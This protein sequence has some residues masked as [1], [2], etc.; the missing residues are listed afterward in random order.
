MTMRSASAAADSEAALERS[1]GRILTIGTWI[2]IALLAIGFVLLL[3]HGLGPRSTDP[4][5]DLSRIP[6]D[7]VALHPEGAIWLGLAIVIATPAARVA[8]ALLGYARRGERAMAVV[9]VL[10]LLVIAASVVVARVTE[11]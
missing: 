10:I 9:A 2:S 6:S 1:I 8:A 5:F 3:A 11:G 4:G 7:L